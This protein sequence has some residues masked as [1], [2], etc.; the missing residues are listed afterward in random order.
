ME[1]YITRVL[2]FLNDDRGLAA[3]TVAAY[4]NDL[5]QFFEYLHERHGAP[6]IDD[7]AEAPMVAATD[8][9]SSQGPV[10]RTMVTEFVLGLRER[11][12]APATVARKIAAIKS[13]F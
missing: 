9:T 12:Y 8:D 10:T 11:G 5:R 4:Q 7:L 2:V 6:P 3:N 1:G 13:L